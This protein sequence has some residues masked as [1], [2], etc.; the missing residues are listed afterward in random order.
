M[1]NKYLGVTALN[2]TGK[3]VALSKF[4][5]IA[6][7]YG[8]SYQLDAFNIAYLIPFML[9]NI[10]KG[11]VTTAFIPY[12]LKTEAQ[13][14]EQLFKGLFIVT[15]FSLVLFSGLGWL[16]YIFAEEI[17]FLIAA[18]ASLDTLLLAKDLLQWLAL[19]IPILGFNGIL[20]SLANAYDRFY[21]PAAESLTTNLFI[22]LLLALATEPSVQ[23]LV[24]SVL[25]GFGVFFLML[26][27]S[28]ISLLKKFRFTLTLKGHGLATP[29]KQVLP[30][31]LGF[32]GA[33]IMSLVDLRYV[34]K[35]GEG[36]YSALNYGIMLST[37]PMEIFV[38][39]VITTMYPVIA[40][41][42]GNKKAL[43]ESFEH[44]MVRILFFSIP[45]AMVLSAL[46]LP[47]II[48]LFY[49][50]AFNEESV[51]LTQQALVFLG[52][53][54]FPQSIAYFCY[55]YLHAANFSWIQIAI[56][57]FGVA[58]NWTLNALL[59]EQYGLLGISFAT[60]FSLCQ[61]ALLSCIA[62]RVR[63]E[64]NAFAIVARSILALAQAIIKLSVVVGLLFAAV[65][66][67]NQVLYQSWLAFSL[68]GA[69]GLGIVFVFFSTSWE[70]VPE[71]N[72][73]KH[74]LASRMRRA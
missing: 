21:I 45:S 60:F 16:V 38:G 25:V 66:Y 62:L 46:S 9:P 42:V 67:L 36:S 32:G 28:N 12:I 37:L 35:L 26:I 40:K 29:F 43:T 48:A 39:A 27:A 20:I 34:S 68:L 44:G 56:G 4:F 15:V 17:V 71:M 14:E 54:I 3:A 5:L 24:Y 22:I 7:A 8:T 41:A 70:A 18:D 74:K 61:S 65:I 59:Y 19:V 10:L 31:S 6:S 23:L 57:Y 64:V 49:R 63:L 55:R 47:I 69:L 73:F 13:D 51:L 11:I 33:F 53:G 50:G 52:L 1:S 58:T 72:G 30:L 2:L